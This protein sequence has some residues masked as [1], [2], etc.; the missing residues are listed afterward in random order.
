MKTTMH[1]MHSFLHTHQSKASFSLR[2]FHIEPRTGICDDQS[3]LLGSSMQF[4][5][6]LADAAVL[7]GVMERLLGNPE[8]AQ[9]VTFGQL[10]GHVDVDL[11]EAEVS[12]LGAGI[13][14]R[15]TLI[16]EIDLHVGGGIEV[17]DSGRVKHQ[18]EHITRR[19]DA[20]GLR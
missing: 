5:G 9:G 17:A 7:H 8:K 3:D 10:R 16:A 11:I 6:E 19:P 18:R 4:Q 14:D 13:S 12:S 20:E 2:L 1:Q 15:E